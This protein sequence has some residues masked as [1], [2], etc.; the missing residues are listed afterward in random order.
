[1][2]SNKYI[3]AAGLLGIC[4]LGS[5]CA[6]TRPVAYTGLASS[7]Y[8]QPNEENAHGRIPY[9]YH[10]EV[11][12]TRYS[13]FILDPVAIYRGPDSQFEKV[14]EQDKR[15]LANFMQQV[16]GETLRQR[17][18]PAVTATAGTIR[19]RLTLTGAKTTKAVLGTV[20]KVDLAGAPYNAVQAM[21]GKE[22]AMM[23]SVSYAVEIYEAG[24]NRLI[25]A[26]VEKQYPNAM[27]FKASLGALAAAKAGVRKGAQQLVDGLD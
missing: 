19:V 22:G 8:L 2:N 21:R 17:Y 24:T 6:S 23:G 20:M 14:T 9:A 13:S 12:W 1:M 3:V 26:Y 4:L 16:F 11:D 15:E 7:N 27:N 18:A 10:A 5:G 25:T